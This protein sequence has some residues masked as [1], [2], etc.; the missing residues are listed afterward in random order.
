RQE[1][2]PVGDAGR[3]RGARECG[4]VLPRALRRGRGGGV[5]RLARA[6]RREHPGAGAGGAGAPAAAPPRRGAGGPGARRR[7]ARARAG[8]TAPGA[9]LLLLGAVY[10][11]VI[12]TFAVGF[13]RVV[14]GWEGEK[15]RKGER[16]N[17]GGGPSP[18]VSVI[19]PARDEAAVIA[20]CLDTVLACDYPAERFEVIV[21]DDLSE[22]DTPAVVER[23]MQRVNAP[24]PAGSDVPE[25]PE[26][27]RLLHMPENLERTRAHKK[28]AIEKG[29]AH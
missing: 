5:Q 23:L 16:E 29:I 13:R 28:R 27:L 9:A 21:V 22:D 17:G 11:A 1:R 6:V 18:F 25:A 20:R 12:G 7:G 4:G 24:V 3:P 8:M 19:V 10:A 26:R 2:D 14:R 15:G